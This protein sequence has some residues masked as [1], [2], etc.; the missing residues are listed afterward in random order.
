MKV[1]YDYL[2]VNKQDGEVFDILRTRKD[3]RYEKN[4]HKGRGYDVKIIQQKYQHI[5]SKE[6]R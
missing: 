3:A 2:I 1:K 5:E 6:V 4:L